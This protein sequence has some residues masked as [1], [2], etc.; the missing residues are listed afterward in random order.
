MCSGLETTCCNLQAEKTIEKIVRK[1]YRLLYHDMLKGEYFRFCP[2]IGKTLYR[3]LILLL[4]ALL[5]IHV[6]QPRFNSEL[7]VHMHVVL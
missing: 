1:E 5:S 7:L 4:L 6:N 3:R 2:S